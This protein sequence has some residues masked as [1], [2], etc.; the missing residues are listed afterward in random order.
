MLLFCL[1]SGTDWQRAG[2]NVGTATP[3]VV[4]N[5]VEVEQSPARF[6]LTPSGVKV[7]A[8]LIREPLAGQNDAA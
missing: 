7:F 4:R 8:A 2:V 3:L 1:A 5:S 6:R